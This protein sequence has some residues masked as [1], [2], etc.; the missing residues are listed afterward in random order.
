MAILLS[1]CEDDEN[2]PCSPHYIDP[3]LSDLLVT[4]NSGFITG[5]LFPI[6]P[7][8]PVRLWAWLILENRNQR[9]AFSLVEIRTAD[10]FPFR[11][12]GTACSGPGG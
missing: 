4:W 11:P 1:S 9:E 7:P 6:A 10:V 12:I 8:D 5:N 3:P 2:C